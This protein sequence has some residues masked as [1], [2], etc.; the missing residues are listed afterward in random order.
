MRCEK[1][2]TV[3]EVTELLGIS[4]STFWRIRKS[5]NFPSSI[6]LGKRALRFCKSEIQDYAFMQSREYI[7]A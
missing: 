1:Y 4:R 3:T 5:A 2:I 7:A 6:M